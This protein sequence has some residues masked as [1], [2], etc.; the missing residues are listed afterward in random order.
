MCVSVF[1]RVSACARVC[2]N[3]SLSE[4]DSS[5]PWSCPFG[6]WG[7]SQTP[8]CDLAMWVQGCQRHCFLA[9]DLLESKIYA[10]GR[11]CKVLPRDCSWGLLSLGMG[12][13]G[14]GWPWGSSEGLGRQLLG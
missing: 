4:A 10:S 12:L 11:S 9:F 1:A 5:C 7:L 6:T 8:H 2:V 13:Q 3:G 14:K